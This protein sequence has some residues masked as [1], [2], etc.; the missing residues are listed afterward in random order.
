MFF[1]EFVYIKCFES[2]LINIIMAYMTAH[3]YN[4]HV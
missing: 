1:G 3:E 4:S 2:Y